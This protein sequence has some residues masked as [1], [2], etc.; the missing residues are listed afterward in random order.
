[1][2]NEGFV[3]KCKAAVAWE[4]NKPLVIEEIE[5]APPQA[6]EVRIKVRVVH[7]KAHTYTYAHVL[8]CF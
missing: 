8:L 4:P 2:S 3:I 1:L 7:N 6:N 5:V